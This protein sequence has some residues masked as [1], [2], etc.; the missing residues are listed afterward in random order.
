MTADFFRFTENTYLNDELY[1]QA[2]F[3][4]DV[5][6]IEKFASEFE[7]EFAYGYVEHLIKA[8]MNGSNFTTTSRKYSFGDVSN[9]YNDLCVDQVPEGKTVHDITVEIE[10]GY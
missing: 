4:V 8:A 7:T 10:I 2:V 9:W 5:S 6:K 1:G 3:I